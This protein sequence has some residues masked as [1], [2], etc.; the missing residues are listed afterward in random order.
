MGWYDCA[1]VEFEF[2]ERPDETSPKPPADGI[3]T[4]FFRGGGG[5]ILTPNSLNVPATAQQVYGR[6]FITGHGGSSF[7]DGGFD[8]GLSCAGGCPGGSCQNCD[9]FCQRD[10]EIKIDGAAA[11]RVTPWR[12]DCSPLSATDCQNW[13]AC[14]WPS[15]TFSRAGWCPGY[16]AC[17]SSGL[18]CEPAEIFCDNASSSRCDRIATDS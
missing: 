12:D 13:N 17:H 4:V 11:W 18:C 14:G 6:F 2:S 9:E 15:C 3:Q 10:H 7:C 1:T 5:E 8:N 16:I